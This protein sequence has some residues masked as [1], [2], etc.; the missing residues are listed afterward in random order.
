MISFVLTSFNDHEILY[1]SYPAGDPKKAQA[2]ID[3]LE[4]P[5]GR[6][7]LYLH[8]LQTGQHK[9]LTQGR[10]WPHVIHGDCVDDDVIIV[11]EEDEEDGG[12]DGGFPIGIQMNKLSVR[13]VDIKV[14]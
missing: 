10:T 11:E 5:P 14:F 13:Y 8:L 2:N 1:F 4:L 12:D 9:P 3:S 6:E 7:G